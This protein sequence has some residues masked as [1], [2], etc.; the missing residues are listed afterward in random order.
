MKVHLIRSEGFKMEDYNNVFNILNQY[1]GGITFV[2][3]EPIVL[4]DTDLEITYDDKGEYGGQI[5]GTKLSVDFFEDRSFPVTEPV[6]SWHY[7]F[8]VCNQYRMD[9]R[10]PSDEQVFLL[11]D[12]KNEENWFGALDERTLNNFFVDCSYWHN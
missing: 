5:L 11:T 7:L 6:Y 3:S 2:P 8:R 12:K 10:I 4:P 9:N 1:S